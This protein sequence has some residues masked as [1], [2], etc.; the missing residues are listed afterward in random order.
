VDA[1]RFREY[2]LSP[3]FRPYLPGKENAM[4]MPK[5]MSDLAEMGID[6]EHFAKARAWFAR[7][8]ITCGY[9]SQRRPGWNF[10]CVGRSDG[11]T[12]VV[13]WLGLEAFVDM[14]DSPTQTVKAMYARGANVSIRK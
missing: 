1:V 2:T 12:Y 13:C 11:P 14:L 6:A 5:H 3:L 10:G 7:R 9:S 8:G 4:R